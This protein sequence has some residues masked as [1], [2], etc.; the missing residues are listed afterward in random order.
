MKIPSIPADK[1]QHIIYG[2][3][4]SLVVTVFLLLLAIL[5]PRTLFLAP[6]A[7]VLAA[8]C[9]GLLTEMRQ[10]VLNERAEARGEVPT[11]KIELGDVTATALGGL[12][13]TLPVL[14]IWV[15]AKL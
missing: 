7:G 6:W 3:L 14:V 13:P 2:A 8:L 12:I 11:H 5:F 10:E 9:L 15:L 1:A 4:A